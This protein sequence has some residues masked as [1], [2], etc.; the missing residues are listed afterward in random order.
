MMKADWSLNDYL[1]ARKKLIDG[2]IE[3]YLPAADACP[4]VLIEAMR[5]SLF[6]GGKRIRPILCLA[7]A[8]AVGGQINTVMPVACALE[9][10]HTYS[11]IHDDLP[12]MDNDDFRR[13]QPTNHK[14][15]GDAMAI[16]AG[17]ALLTE[18]FHLMTR[19]DQ[20]AEADPEALLNIIR[21]VAQAA[22]YD[23]MVGGQAVDILSEG[24]E[25]DPDSL[26]YI[27]TH[28]TAALICA[29]IKAGAVL[30]GAKATELDALA[31]YGNHIGLAFQIADDILNVEGDR[32][33]LGKSTGSDASRGKLTYPGL[34][35][36]E[37]ARKKALELT[38]SAL[39][40]IDLFDNRAL[41]LKRIAEYIMERKT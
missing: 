2:A 17:D 35:G 41:P 16:L 39:R 18:A 24:L 26:H 25:G 20:T 13:G 22:G 1:T 33:I 14:V 40:D 7:A 12:A 36:L 5:Y 9:M 8:E 28:K 37:A 21:D 34:V 6:A 19:R 29:S 27:H 11:L 30:S 4:S 23:G 32:D 3:A 31:A 15:F 10:I 38:E